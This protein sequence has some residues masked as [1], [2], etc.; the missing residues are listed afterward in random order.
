MT[1]RKWLRADYRDVLA[2]IEEVEAEWRAAQNR[3]R[4]NWWDVLA[5]GPNGTPCVVAGREFPVLRAAQIRKRVPVT[6]NA[7][8]RNEEEIAPN[9]RFG[10]W[11]RRRVRA[12]TTAPK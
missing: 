9:F 10:R 11:R 8:C 7:L 4:R 5:G 6:A 12:K 3:Q 2:L 1:I